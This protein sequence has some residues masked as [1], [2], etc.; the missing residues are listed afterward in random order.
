MVLNKVKGNMYS[1]VN[2]TW[3][4]ISGRCKHYCGYCYNIG[5]PFFEG[6]LRLM[7]NN[8]N[9]NLGEN[10]FIFIGSSN[11]LFQQEIPSDWIGRTL[12]HCS[13]YPKNQYLFQ[14]KNPD[15]MRNFLE[16]FPNSA[17]LGTTLETN[18][19]VYMSNA[20]SPKERV[21]AMLKL[22]KCRTTVTI[23]PIMDFDLDI[24]AGWIR[25]IKPEFVSI[26]ADSKNH[27][28]QEPSWEKIQE[29]ILGLK[30]FTNVRIK[31]NLKRL[32]K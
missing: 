14:S 18:R 20:P 30:K 15:R 24:F 10:N 4:T 5:K 21:S 27:H 32:K 2:F 19:D 25:D 8:L 6:E 31:E 11:D 26:G 28:L 1:F 22:N 9:D 23:E 7:E 13:K 17:I 29:L 16:L 3:N 12:E